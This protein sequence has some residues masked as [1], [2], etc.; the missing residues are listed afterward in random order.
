MTWIEKVLGIK[1]NKDKFAEIA[2]KAIKEHS[3]NSKIDYDPIEFML[4]L[5]D[6]DGAISG[7]YYLGNAY[8][9]YCTASRLEKDKVLKSF[10]GPMPEIPQALDAARQHLLPCV[11]ARSFFEENRL[12]PIAGGDKSLDLPYKIIAE[13]FAVS[14]VFDG[15]ETIM[16]IDSNQYKKWNTSID[17]L[18]PGAIA[19]L[20]EATECPAEMVFPGVYLYNLADSHDASRLMLIDRIRQCQ[21]QGRPVMMI[22]NRDLLI[23]T[24]ESD[25]D[26]QSKMLQIANQALNEIRSVL[27]IPLV[28][29]GDD[30]Y[31][32]QPSDYHPDCQQF[33]YLKLSSLAGIYEAEKV[34]LESRYE[35]DGTDIF[36]ASFMVLQSE[37]TGRYWSTASWAEGVDT[38][39][40]EVD[41]I[42]FVGADQELKCMAPWVEAQEIVGSRMT[43]LDSYPKRYRVE[44]FPDA[45]ELLEL[46]KHSTL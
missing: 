14:L 42:S 21:V 17:E 43:A 16:Q 12:L 38:L 8:E 3:G 41:S 1:P 22:P 26:G 30:W 32:W 2:R 27:G 31:C 24:G 36:V 9:V 34:R 45:S 15:P 10:F 25:H 46:A 7:S 37:D 19:N 44:S 18:L 13:H 39:L 11:R 28:L 6:A 20:V 35:A 4:V 29:S 33:G 40:P 5:H 23:I